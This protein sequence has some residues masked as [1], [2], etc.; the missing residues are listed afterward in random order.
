MIPWKMFWTVLGAVVSMATAA[1]L[2][3]FHVPMLISVPIVVVAAGGCSIAAKTTVG[4][5]DV[6]DKLTR[7]RRQVIARWVTG[8][9]AIHA[10]W[11]ILFQLR[12]V[13]WLAWLVALLA[14]AG[15][16][17]GVARSQEYMLAR[18]TPAPSKELAVAPGTSA[19][20]GNDSGTAVHQQFATPEDE[21][22]AKIGWALMLSGHSWLQI[23]EPAVIVAL[24]TGRPL[25]VRALLEIEL[26][27]QNVAI[28]V[29]RAGRRS[30]KPQEKIELTAEDRK[31]M[32]IALRQITGTKLYSDWVSLI[33]QPE[34][35]VY[36][37]V[38]L[39]EDVLS[40]VRPFV[41]DLS[42]TTSRDPQMGGYEVNGQP[43]Y[44]RLDQHGADIGQSR[45]G[46]SSKINCK[47][48]ATTKMTNAT[49]W[50]CG[51]S[52]LYDLIAGWIA[53][54]EG[55]EFKHPFG[56]VVFGPQHT[57]IML[58]T[59]LVIARWRQNQPMDARRNFKTIF[60]QFDEAN[61]PSALQN[62]TISVKID[63]VAYTM[64][65]LAYS[66][67]NEAGGAEVWLHLACH[68]LTDPNF[69]PH[70]TDINNGLAWKSVFHVGDIAEIGRATEDYNLENPR[71]KGEFWDNPGADDPIIKLKAPYIQEIDPSKPKL[72]DGLT[73]SDVAWARRMF[74]HDLDEGSARVAAEFAGALYSNRFQYATPEFDHYLRN[75][76]PMADADDSDEEDRHGE[77][78]GGVEMAA[79]SYDVAFA[80]TAAELDAL[81]AGASAPVAGS[82]SAA[83]AVESEGMATVVTT[84]PR[85]TVRERIVAIVQASDEELTRGDIIAALAEEGPEVK[86]QVVTNTLGDL[87][88]DG[89]AV[90]RNEGG[91]YCAA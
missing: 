8:A 35:G 31:K 82:S 86:A 59:A 12:P 88:K 52:K 25:G 4:V 75:A 64:S 1:G 68:R 72:H 69:G 58:A 13:L 81:F 42:P 55:T 91:R 84:L 15:V 10:S 60:I 17:Y 11:I 32:A 28:A 2:A 46:K 57:L 50:V 26:M 62:T 39:F 33:E 5:A 29:A 53:P 21:V 90:V 24:D 45:W 85:R 71:H 36:E 87:V 7:A 18:R 41:D 23:S 80:E 38:V 37:L 78:V 66:L 3:L 22:H 34:A 19:V 83:E 79:D 56:W 16:E 14:L 48:A 6:F 74:G 67:V 61:A 9:I 70:T 47:L 77:N 49:Q 89:S 65:K 73:V 27:T 44:R 20:V 63:G 30:S 76:G 54:Y 51:T 40:A 43:T